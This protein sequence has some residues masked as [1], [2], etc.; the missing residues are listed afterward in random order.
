MPGE[1]TF[2]RMPRSK[3]KTSAEG[4][5]QLSNS[6]ARMAST[7]VA[8][9]RV[10]ITEVGFAQCRFVVD[11]R[12]F[13]ALCCGEP[14][15]GG[16]WCAHHRALVFVRVAALNHRKPAQEPPKAPVSVSETVPNGPVKR[17]ESQATKPGQDSLP[18]PDKHKPKT[19]HVSPPTQ[20]GDTPAKG[21]KPPEDVIAK[22][23]GAG[24]AQRGAPPERKEGTKIRSKGEGKQA[25]AA[26]VARSD[27]SGTAK[28][29]APSRK[30]APAKPAQKKA[31]PSRKGSAAK[32]PASVKKAAAS[33]KSSAAKRP[34]P[35]KKAAASRK[36]SAA[37]RPLPAKKPAAM[38]KSTAAK[39]TASAKKTAAGKRKSR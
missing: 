12:S 34:A 15:L 3:P 20:R 2:L 28:K 14:T 26:A 36:S 21:A 35:A 9:K 19:Q 22:K 5:E 8:S 11:D 6:L 10:P 17:P 23:D 38:R 4:Q 24:A 1:V 39:R 30:S 32:V 33:R 29:P 27:R 25:E 31:A 18:S 37:K 13:P 16:S 7:P